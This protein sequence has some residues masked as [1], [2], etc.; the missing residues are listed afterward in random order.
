MVDRA[1]SAGAAPVAGGMAAGARQ[2]PL[3]L[4]ILYTL[5]VCLLVPVYW[6]H[7]GPANFLWFSDIALLTTVVALWIESPLLASMMALAVALP[8]LAWNIGFFAR[9][10]FGVNVGGLSGYMFEP[11]TPLYLR[12]LSL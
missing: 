4:K 8:E 11:K 10:I 2:F 7:Y 5:Y 9:L 12:G 1:L 3:W 6:I